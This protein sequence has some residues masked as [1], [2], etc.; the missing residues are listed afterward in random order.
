M[1]SLTL[2]AVIVQDEGISALLP[3]VTRVSLKVVVPWLSGADGG[4]TK[5]GSVEVI[6]APV[7]SCGTTFQ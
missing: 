6:D 5:Y 7:P 2:V 1:L 4:A 3:L